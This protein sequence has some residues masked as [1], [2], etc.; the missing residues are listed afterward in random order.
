[1]AQLPKPVRLT[2]RLAL[3]ALAYAI[4]ARLS[5]NLALV[6]GQV[7]PIWPPTGIALVTFLLLGRGMWPA[8]YL[9]AF[10]VN[11]PIGPSPLGAAVIAVGNTLAPLVAAE[12]LRRVGFRREVDRLRDALAIT[13]MAALGSMAISAT[14]GTMVL[15]L[16]GVIS[17]A[18]FPT[19]WAVWWTGDAMG[20]LL[21]APFLLSVFGLGAA[22][23]LTIRMAVEIT[24][25]LVATAVI[26]YLLF[27]NDLR[28]EYLVLPVI[29]VAAWRFRLRGAAPAALVAS[30]VAVVCAVNGLGPFAEE[31][32]FQKMATLQVFNV[33]LALASFVLAAFIEA[34]ERKEEMS[35]LYASAQ[36]ANHAK[37]RFLHLAAH[38]L[39]TPITVITGYL[40]MLSDGSLGPVP[41]GWK[42]PLDVLAN[43]TKELNHLVSDLLEAS[44][45]EA[46]A[47]ATVAV[48]LD[49]REV[50]RQ[51][52]ERAQPRGDLVGAEIVVKN[53]PQPV[54]VDADAAQ[55]GRVLD[56]L[57][58]N[59]MTYN[60]NAPHVVVT[61]STKGDQA[62]VRVGDNGVGIPPDERERIFEQFH[63]TNDPSFLNVPGTG[64]GLYISRQLAQANGATLTLESSSPQEGAV[65]LLT[66]PAVP[67]PAEVT[68]ADEAL[69]SMTPV[70]HPIATPGR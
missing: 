69:A 22:P 28:L 55:L 35:R 61:V 21:V 18:Q 14:I 41:N 65:F 38:E 48:R 13:V 5:L 57:I 50:A 67:T 32:L 6:H 24:G 1:V 12:L 9:A 4:A 63:R 3:V 52:V 59:A 54:L 30:G 49:L 39:R 51:A 70:R 2:I 60:L 25:L 27:L 33:S 44:R 37:S 19:T 11:L 36:A 64:L 17:E 68:A 46:N 8:I 62:S 56:N 26:T 10:A 23:P 43:K 53:P 29:M 16:G 58:N 15:L 31:T 42:Q 34:R 7:T 66:L 20:V 47:V 40:A 45:T